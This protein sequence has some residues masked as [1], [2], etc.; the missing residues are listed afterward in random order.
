M[1]ETSQETETA[2]A[3]ILDLGRQSPKKIKKLRKGKG[4]LLGDIEATVAELKTK[5]VVPEDA[6]VV[7]VVVR[8]KRPRNPFGL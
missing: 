7:V 1:T 8:E 3:T 6:H 2:Q 4:P 5:G